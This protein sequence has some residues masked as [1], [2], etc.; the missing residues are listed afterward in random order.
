MQCPTDDTLGALVE[1]ALDDQEAAR[2]SSHIDSCDACQAIVVAA[3]RGEKQ[4]PVPAKFPAGTPSLPVVEK[5]DPAA[6]VGTRMGRYELKSLLGAGGMGQVYTAYDAEL[7]RSIALKVLRPELAR[8]A[9]VLA[10]RLLRESRL[11]AKVAHPS[12]ISIFDVGRQGDAVFIAMELV[13]GGT[14]ASYLARAKPAWR[15]VASIFE[16]AGRGLA[17][18]HEAG[19]VHRD[20]KPENVLVETRDGDVTRVVVTDFGIAMVAAL[21][22]AIPSEPAGPKHVDP[23]LTATGVAIGTPAYMAPEQLAGGAVDRRADVFAFS[24]SLWEALFGERPFPGNSI[25]EIRAAMRRTPRAPQSSV[26]SRLVRVLERGLA[27]NPDYRWPDM[28]PLVRELVAVRSKRRRTIAIA[29]LGGVGLVGAGIAGAL[30]LTGDDKVDPCARPFAFDT[31]VTIDA[32]TRQRLVDNVTAWRTTHA[33]T[34]KADRDP[35][36]SSTVAACLDARKLEIEA[37]VADAR[38]DGSKASRLVRVMADPARCK[39]PPAGLLFARVPSDPAQRRVV[40]DLRYRAFEIESLRDRSQFDVALPKAKALVEEA[41]SAWPPAHAETLYLLGTTQAMGGG[42]TDAIATLR[43]AAA[44]GERTHHVH[45]A[46]NS[47]IQLVLS[48]AFDAGDPTRALE[49]ATYA[50]AALDKIGRPPELETLFL[51]HKGT[52]MLEGGQGKEAEPILRRAVELAQKHAPQ[53][54][55]RTMLGLGYFYEAQGRYADAVEA[56]RG[57]IKQLDSGTGP[58]TSAHTFR[59]RLA[60]NLALLGHAEEAERVAREAVAL[61]EKTVGEDNVDRAIVH[62][63]LAQVLSTIGKPEDAL[64]AVRQGETLIRK[65]LGERSE[66]RGEVLSLEGNILSELGRFDEAN[67]TLA[68]ACE[69]IAFGAGENSSPHADCLLSQS[70]A[71]SELGRTKE[72]LALVDRGVDAL[73]AIDGEVHP[74]VASALVQRGAL[75]A[76]L[77]RTDEGIADLERAVAAFEQLQLEAGHLGGAKWALGKY[78]WKRDRARARKLIEEAIALFTSDAWAQSKADAEEF[79]RTAR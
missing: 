21:A 18:A 31:N 6:L 53:Y 52:A 24:G 39:D 54:L 63:T 56:Y 72:A 3:V 16:R 46:A 2:I 29:A 59:E 78:L 65:I 69:I 28:Q 75:R 1:H 71:L 58:N 19:I 36:Q 61:A 48:A 37:F 55:A 68:R 26:P 70:I 67:K 30:L 77:G 51:Y 12:V 66:R 11:M 49:Y 13:R 15:D 27:I 33:A 40:T 41:K 20:F 22:D 4:T 73:I 74:R 79:L 34:C 42:A 43:E 38:L 9:S 45:I 7:D 60:I 50:D 10:E 62:T 44:L 5:A 17:A 57:A 8:A 64:V 23:R 14:L 76:M 25:D 32:A 47:W 35:P